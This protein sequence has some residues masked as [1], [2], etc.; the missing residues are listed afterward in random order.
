LNSAL[1]DKGLTKQGAKMI[2]KKVFK[3]NHIDIIKE[4]EVFTYIESLLKKFKQL[5]PLE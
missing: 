1:Y 4:T 3:L 2:G 5:M